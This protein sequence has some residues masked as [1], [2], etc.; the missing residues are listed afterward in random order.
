MQNMCNGSSCR[1]CSSVSVWAFITRPVCVIQSHHNHHQRKRLWS[2]P[3][4]RISAGTRI[5]RSCSAEWLDWLSAQ[6]KE[7]TGGCLSR[8]VCWPRC[9]IIS[10]VFH[11]QRKKKI[12]ITR[13]RLTG[14][15]PLSG[16]RLFRVP[17]HRC[18]Y[19]FFYR[20][21]RVLLSC[22]QETALVVFVA[23]NRLTPS[24]HGHRPRFELLISS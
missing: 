8:I 10:F 5:G 24:R 22:I 3:R 20:E 18:S 21:Y 6:S 9:T 2:A 12:R 16:G 15:R 17:Q 4:T 11:N 14:S 1:C 23:S 13:T 7:R 19:T